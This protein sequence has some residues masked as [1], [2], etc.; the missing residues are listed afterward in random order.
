MLEEKQSHQFPS[1]RRSMKRLLHFQEPVHV[2]KWILWKRT[3]D[4]RH[5]SL[6][7][8]IWKVT[9]TTFSHHSLV[10]TLSPCFRISTRHLQKQ[11]TPKGRVFCHY[12]MCN[13]TAESKNTCWGADN[14]H[15]TLRLGFIICSL[16]SQERDKYHRSIL[17]RSQ[18]KVILM[19]P[20]L[21][22]HWGF[23]DELQHRTKY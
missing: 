4:T 23:R 14:T 7:Q 15:G 5:T 11:R 2:R 13:V 10:V 22:Q 9:R 8:K 18:E 19:S 17:G 1:W 20:N 3:A 12:F 21:P 6:S 16:K